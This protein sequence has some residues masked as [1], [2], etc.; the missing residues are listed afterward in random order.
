MPQWSAFLH[1]HTIARMQS[2]SCLV[3]FAKS[4][5]A[6]RVSAAAQ[7]NLR[8]IQSVS[9]PEASVSKGYDNHVRRSPGIANMGSTDEH[10]FLNSLMLLSI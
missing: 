6:A 3:A 4:L 7:K 1:V 2:A 9:R 5:E 8:S 10:S